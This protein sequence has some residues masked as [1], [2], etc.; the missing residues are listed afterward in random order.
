MPWFEQLPRPLVL[1]PGDLGEPPNLDDAHGCREFV[2]PAVQPLDAVA[3][4]AIVTERAHVLDDLGVPRDHG[5]T[6]AGRD[7][8]GRCERPDACVAPRS[9]A[10]AVPARSMCV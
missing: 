10:S 6:L 8:L 2:H 3:R 1:P 9:G 7:R 5:T 4:L